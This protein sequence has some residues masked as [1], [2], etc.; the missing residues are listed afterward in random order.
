MKSKNSEQFNILNKEE[1]LL[2][3]EKDEPVCPQ[4]VHNKEKTITWEMEWDKYNWELLLVQNFLKGYFEGFISTPE[5]KKK[6][7]IIKF[8]PILPWLASFR[9]TWGIYVFLIGSH[10]GAEQLSSKEMACLVG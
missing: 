5:R 4:N 2:R 8:Q 6:K 7:S 9:E 3:V 1:S 10:G